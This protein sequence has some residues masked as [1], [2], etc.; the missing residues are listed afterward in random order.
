MH[1]LT[2]NPFKDE[3]VLISKFTDKIEEYTLD[4]E[5]TPWLT[6]VMD[7]ITKD[8]DKSDFPE[9]SEKLAV[10]LKYKRDLDREFGEYFWISGKI[11]GSYFANCVRCLINVPMKF[12]SDFKG[13]YINQ[14]FEKQ[15]EF[16]ELDE[17]YLAGETV[18]LHFHIRGKANI[19]DII[20][21]ATFLAVDHY[22]LHDA[23]CKG[24]CHTCGI[25]LN[26]GTCEHKN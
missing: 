11:S 18:D 13:A 7:K 2:A 8:F 9:N 17:L 3:T 14:H 21:E 26:S 1:H 12:E 24:L 20:S 6:K 23:E 16:A 15:E 5:N 19:A 4:L 22:P 10:S 25:D